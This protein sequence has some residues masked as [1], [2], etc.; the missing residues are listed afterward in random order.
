MTI[1]P[2]AFSGRRACVRRNPFLDLDGDYSAAAD[3]RREAR[4]VT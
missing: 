4:F 2:D 3:A 1:A